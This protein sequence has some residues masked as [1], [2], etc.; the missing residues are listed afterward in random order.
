MFVKLLGFL[1]NGFVARVLQIP[2]LSNRQIKLLYKIF[3]NVAFSR[4]HFLKV[5]RDLLQCR[6]VFILDI[7]STSYGLCQSFYHFVELRPENKVL[8][9]TLQ[10]EMEILSYFRLTCLIVDKASECRMFS[11]NGQPMLENYFS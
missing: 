1:S 3:D 8:N 2:T 6:S 5:Y 11:K 10:N 7:V 4:S 9:L